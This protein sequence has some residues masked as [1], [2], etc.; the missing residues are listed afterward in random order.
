MNFMEKHDSYLGRLSVS[1]GGSVWLQ[2]NE[3]FLSKPDAGECYSTSPSYAC[4]A[5][6]Y[7]KGGIK[8]EENESRRYHF[9]AA[10]NPDLLSSFSDH[11]Y[12]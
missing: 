1:I 6:T 2:A 12:W 3:H 9:V 4:S 8:N 5:I 7:M 10:L 11:P